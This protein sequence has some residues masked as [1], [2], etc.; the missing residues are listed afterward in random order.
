MI[1]RKVIIFQLESLVDVLDYSK[2]VANRFTFC[3]KLYKIS[4]SIIQERGAEGLERKRKRGTKRETKKGMKKEREEERCK[5]ILTD[6]TPCHIVILVDQ[7]SS[8][9]Y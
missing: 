6:F 9:K 8:N 1:N 3:E 4:Y 2:H 7:R 5:P